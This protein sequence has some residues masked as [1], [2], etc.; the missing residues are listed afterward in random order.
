[1]VSEGRR[2]DR[3]LSVKDALGE[4]LAEIRMLRVH[5]RART[6]VR[7]RWPSLWLLR[8]HASTCTCKVV[9]R[10]Q[11]CMQS[12]MLSRCMRGVSAAAERLP[13]REDASHGVSYD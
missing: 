2:D 12:P 3:M 9:G 4:S 7:Y 1:M 10:G 6:L 11:A 5:G 13:A 8:H